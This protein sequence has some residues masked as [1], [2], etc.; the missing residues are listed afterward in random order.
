MNLGKK[1]TNLRKRE[2]I[3]QEKIAEIIG[4]TRQTI[5]NWELNITKPDINQIKEISKIFNI[6]I[7][8]LVGNDIKNIF[9]EKV[10]KTE[11]IVNKNTKNIRILVITIYFILL[12]SLIF[13]TI[14]LLTKKDFTREY[15]PEFTCI[16][17]E[18]TVY[19]ISVDS[20]FFQEEDVKP[21]EH[22]NNIMNTEYFIIVSE[23]DPKTNNYSVIERYYA[24]KTL[25]EIILEASGTIGE[26]LS[27]RRVQRVTKNENQVFGA[28]KH[29]G[30]RIV[31]LV[32]L[33]GSDAEC[34]KDV[35][36]HIAALGPKY[37][38]SD[39]ISAE[40]VQKE[41]EIL[42]AQALN[43]NETA[44]KPKPQQIIE[45]MVEGRLTK[46]F[47]EICLLDQPFVKNPDQTVATFVK[48][49]GCEVVSFLRLAVGEGIEKEVVD[50]AA[51]VAA[52]A[53]LK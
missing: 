13:I 28:Y 15:Q 16:S 42:L 47:K 4:V 45:K 7:D 26:K 43:E 33:D 30:G 51:E 10:N 39:E 6:S 11:T 27:L 41:R 49:K 21:E 22:L 14:Y 24:G 25:N 40:E 29:M 12:S 17:K 3:T 18:G 35:A 46:N 20:E 8:E 52:Q 34:A 36:M 9:I 2:K 50:F 44:A 5:S 38:S 48:S 23:Q 32:L 31:S 53:G 37:V 1:L 19:N